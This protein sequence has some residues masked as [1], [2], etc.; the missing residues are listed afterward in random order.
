MTNSIPLHLHEVLDSQRQAIL[1]YL[2]EIKN[3]WFVLGWGTGLAL[4][5]GHRESIDFDF[6]INKDI[7]TQDLFEKCLTLFRDFE[8]IKTYEE[9]NTLYIIVHEVKISFFSYTHKNIWNIIETPY[10][11]IFSMAD[12]GC[13]KLW[14][15]QNRATNKDYVDLYYI[16]HEI[17]LEKLLY[18]FFEKFWNVVTKSYLLK[19]LVYFDDII[20][21]ELIIKD[22]ELS[23]KKVKKY[24]E[25]SIDSN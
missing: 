23:F 18:I 10:F 3:M 14:A 1:E 12:I 11:N 13:M 6:F 21:E 19:S 17:W 7:D 22:T 15:I 16:I 8:V 25:K 4:L 20:E 2:I 24:L 5:F 9:K